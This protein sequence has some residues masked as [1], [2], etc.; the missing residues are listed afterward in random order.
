MKINQFKIGTRLAAGNAILLALI[1]LVA[2]VGLRGMSR[3]NEALARITEVNVAKLALLEQMTSSVHVVMRVIRTMALIDDPAEAQGEFVKITAAREQYDGAL[4]KLEAMP[5][6]ETGKATVARLKETQ[7]AARPL[8]N[9][10]LELVRTDR[11]AAI[12]LL[13]T[14]GAAANT[15]WQEQ[16]QNYAQY[17]RRKN[18]QDAIDA[19]RTYA[20]ARTWMLA[21]LAAALVLGGAL[22][23]LQER[24]IVQP[25]RTAVGVA[26]TVAAGDLS[27]AITSDARD[28]TGDLLRALADMNNR[29]RDTVTHVRGGAGQVAAAAAQIAAGNHD[30]S[31]RTEQQAGSLEETAASMEQISGNVGQSMDSAQSAH[32]LAQRA[33]GEAE[34]GG[35]VVA[36][37]IATMGRIDDASRKIGEITSVIDGIA[38][39]TNILALNAAVEAARAGEQGRGF[40]VV[41]GE[42]RS[43]AQRCTAAAREIKGLIEDSNAR[44]EEG[45]RQVNLAGAA[46]GQVVERV[47]QVSHVVDEISR[48]SR[49]Q[50]AGIGQ[51]NEA[52]SQ[53]DAVTQQNAALVEE[54]ASAADAL[55]EQAAALEQLVSVFNTGAARA[56]RA[57]QLSTM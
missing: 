54:A 35:Q 34:H 7:A 33:A 6:D 2:M 43:L 14:D 42:V 18:A 48:A 3:G 40:A 50:H 31:S 12:K 25:L 29:L 24:A 53:M 57:A 21:S 16:L 8:N 5:L 55:Q 49:E 23:W 1:V 19:A 44:V 39:Q 9:R 27:A 41:A 22:A 37:V 47:R 46:I 36:Q 56:T 45:A 38:F 4:R 32:E 13:R 51:V 11:Q 30:L 10:F 26:R 15:R 28:E 52:L 17:Q 20:D